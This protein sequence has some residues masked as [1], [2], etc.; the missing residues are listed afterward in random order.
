MAFKCFLTPEQKEH[1]AK[2]IAVRSAEHFLKD[3]AKD[4]NKSNSNLREALLYL[5]ESGVV[6]VDLN[7][8]PITDGDMNPYLFTYVREKVTEAKTIL[9]M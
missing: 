5:Q 2:R 3:C 1:T 7:K 6:E 4:L 9:N 8:F